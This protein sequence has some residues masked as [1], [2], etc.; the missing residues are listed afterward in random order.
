MKVNSGK[1][2]E[3]ESTVSKQG[4]SPD[5]RHNLRTALSAA[6]AGIAM[7]LEELDGPLTSA[8]RETLTIV[9]KNIERLDQL[10]QKSF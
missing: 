2:N 5:F 10:I 4:A 1:N 3:E 9:K 7:L 8:Q 6:N